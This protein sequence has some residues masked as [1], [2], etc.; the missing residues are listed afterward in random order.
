MKLRLELVTTISSDLLD[1]KWELGNDVINKGDRVLLRMTSVYFEC[2]HACC[3]VDGG[4]LISLY[5]LA[6]FILEYQKLNIH[7]N[8]MARYPLV[9]AFRMHLSTTHFAR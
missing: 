8:V 7:L 4:V 1:T 2:S 3:V 6:R 5:L 9:V